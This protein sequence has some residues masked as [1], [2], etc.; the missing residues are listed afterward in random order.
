MLDLAWAE[1]AAHQRDNPTGHA[2]AVLTLRADDADAS[3][4]D[5]AAA[6]SAQVGEPIRPDRFRQLLRRARVR[7][8]EALVREIGDGLADPTP[9]RIEEELIALGLHTRVRGLLPDAWAETL[10]R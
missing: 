1:L 10:G 6:L 9:D 4:A 8:A 7:F 5:L 2:H 3:A